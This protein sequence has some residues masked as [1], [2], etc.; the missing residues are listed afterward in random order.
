LNNGTA[1]NIAVWATLA[2][3]AYYPG[4]QPDGFYSGGT[5]DEPFVGKRGSW[6]AWTWGDALFIA[7]DPYW[8]TKTKI[9][10]D[11]WVLTLGKAQYDWLASTLSA[12]DAK[13]RFVFIHNLVGGLDGQMRGGVE[14][15]PYYEWGGKNPDDTSGFD[16]MR[17]GWGK[18]IHQLL[19]E[20]HVTAVFHGH[21]HVYVKQEL[22]GIVYQEMSQPSSPNF[23]GG[24]GLAAKMHYDSGTIQSSS[25]H[26]RISV[27]PDKVKVEYVRA[28]RPED[29]NASR[30]NGDVSDSYTLAPR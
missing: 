15:A 8:S 7:L 6:Y 22:D 2:R 4:P 29:E 5:A 20:N 3:K 23:T 26:L 30:H 9:G 11:G 18:P 14:A 12:S 16:S 27:A 10:K 25:G 28:Y 24:P 17:P 13:F 21:D 1:D 19:V